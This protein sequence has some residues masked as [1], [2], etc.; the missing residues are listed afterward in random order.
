MKVNTNHHFS[1][2]FNLIYN[3]AVRVTTDTHI[4]RPSGSNGRTVKNFTD[5]IVV[6]MFDEQLMKFIS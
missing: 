5:E 6:N 2:H 3:L 1:R 4:V